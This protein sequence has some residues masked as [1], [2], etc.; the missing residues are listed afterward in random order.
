MVRPV[1]RGRS[2]VYAVLAL[3]AFLA[4]AGSASGGDSASRPTWVGTVDV[5]GSDKVPGVFNTWDTYKLTARAVFDGRRVARFPT[6]YRGTLTYTSELAI[7]QGENPDRELPCRWV[8]S[9]KY[10]VLIRIYG[11]GGEGVRPHTQVD[12]GIAPQVG[13]G[14]VTQTCNWGP[15]VGE[16]TKTADLA[17]GM[18]M[19]MPLTFSIPT[20]ATSFKKTFKPVVSWADHRTRSA[21]VRLAFKLKR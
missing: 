20:K 8:G 17:R 19:V 16:E 6:D 4:I 9:G 15:S 21:T 18:P 1:G 7:R 3:A 12:L 2:V 14:T 11:A 10:L 5:S 13:M